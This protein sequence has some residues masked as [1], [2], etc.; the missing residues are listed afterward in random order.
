[1]QGAIN[2]GFAKFTEALFVAEQQARQAVELRSKVQQE[3]A[4]R[5]KAA[6][7]AELRNL[8]IR[9][10]HSPLTLSASWH[11]VCSGRLMILQVPSLAG[12]LC[13][14]HE[15]DQCYCQRSVQRRDTTEL[16]RARQERAGAAPSLA[17]RAA[18]AT[19]PSGIGA[20]LPGPP[21]GG[22]PGADAYP[23][24]PP[25]PQGQRESREEREE[26]VRRDEIR[27]DRRGA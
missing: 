14:R 10:P 15:G 11:M 17:E 5:E 27:K 19:V 22:P 2:D 24:P 12:Q 13:A 25:P 21:P 8:A 7:D 23:P 26:R 9:Y 18:G 6:K 16:C 4:H 3:I 20:D 1:M